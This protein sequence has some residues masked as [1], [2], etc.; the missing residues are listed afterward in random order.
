MICGTRVRRN[1]DEQRVTAR[2]KKNNSFSKEI[3]RK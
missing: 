1:E 3:N 2:Y